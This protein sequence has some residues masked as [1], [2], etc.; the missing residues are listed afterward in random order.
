MKAETSFKK[1]ARKRLNELPRSWWLNVQMVALRGVPDIIGCLG[2]RFV[3]LELKKDQSTLEANRDGG[4]LQGW[5][6]RRIAAAGGYARKVAP[7]QF[8]AVFEE[9][10]ELAALKR[11]D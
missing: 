11:L 2:G 4:I 8:D 1:S 10:K 3:A 5:V 6:L 7:E 9:L